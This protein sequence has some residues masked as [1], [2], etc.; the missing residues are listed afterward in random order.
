MNSSALWKVFAR[1]LRAIG[2]WIIGVARRRGIPFLVD[3]MQERIGVF[4]K[5]IAKTKGSSARAKRRRAWLRGRIRRWTRA[6]N[7]LVGQSVE[8]HQAALCEFEKLAAKIPEESP[9]EREPK[10]KRA[11]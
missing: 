5:R 4:Q 1:I 8:L 7:W 10:A 6:A 2:R 9:L 11:A 3:Y